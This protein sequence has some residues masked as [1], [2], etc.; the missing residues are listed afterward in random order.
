MA[1]LVS[2]KETGSLKFLFGLQSLCI[3]DLDQFKLCRA[4]VE[5]KAFKIF[6]E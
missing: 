2:K 3:E 6:N 1:T 5:T 4:F